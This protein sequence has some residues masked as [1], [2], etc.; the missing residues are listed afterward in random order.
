MVRIESR[1]SAVRGGRATRSRVA[2]A[3]V[4]L[5]VVPLVATGC[6][7]SSSGGS[8]TSKPQRGGDLTIANSMDI[9]TL[10][11]TRMFHNEDIWMSEQFFE[12]LYAAAPDGK[13]LVPKLA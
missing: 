4:G 3:I 1:R 2:S 8:D 7:G 12:T 11:K 13:S 10:D 6:N 5:V 9:Q